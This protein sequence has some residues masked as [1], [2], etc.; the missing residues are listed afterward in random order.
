MIIISKMYRHIKIFCGPD[1]TVILIDN[2]AYICGSDIRRITRNASHYKSNQFNRIH[3]EQKIS[4]I[5][6][7]YSR[8]FMLTATNKIYVGGSNYD[9]QLGLRHQRNQQFPTLLKLDSELKIKMI[10]C[11]SYRTMIITENRECFA[12]GYNACGELG[13]GDNYK[14]Y[15]TFQ[16]LLVNDVITVSCMQFSTFILTKSGCFVCGSNSVGQLGLGNYIQQN[17]LQRLELSNIIALECGESYAFALASDGIY[18]WGCN[19]NGEL[20]I[21]KHHKNKNS[22]QKVD[23]GNLITARVVSIRC[24]SFPTVFLT[25]LGELFI[26][27]DDGDQIFK[28]LHLDK[29]VVSIDCGQSHVIAVTSD[30]NMYGWGS[31]TD[32]QLGLGDDRYV[33]HKKPC[34]LEL[35]I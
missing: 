29:F 31:N 13:F 11:M 2:Y 20:G 5:H 34:R 10:K 6:L 19:D 9:G 4:S 18:S 28:K 21:G 27:D 1:N 24:G 17:S 12:C 23:F 26:C 3:F 8:L 30:G 15:N 33:Y 35:K 16:K 32:G 14:R 7:Q 25:E 22:P